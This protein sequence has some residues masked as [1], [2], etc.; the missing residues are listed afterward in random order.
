MQNGL[1]SFDEAVRL[2][3]SGRSFAVAADRALL[4]RL[5][6]GSWIGGSIPYFVGQDGGECSREKVFVSEIPVLGAAPEIRF[7]ERGE[8]PR[9]FA[10]APDNGFSLIVIPAFSQAHF[11]FARY[12]PEYEDAYFKPLVGWIAGVHLDD[13]DKER[14]IVAHGGQ[15]TSRALSETAAVVMH[16]PL[17]AGRSARI[18]IVNLFRPGRGPAIRFPHTGFG[19]GP[20]LIDGEPANLAEYLLANKIDT[21]VPLVADYCGAMVNVSIRGVDADKRSVD[22][23]APVFAHMEY[24]IAE[25]VDDYVAAFAAALP[26]GGSDA[27]FSCNCILNYVHSQLAGKRTGALV[28]P[29]TFGEVAYQLLNQTLVYLRIDG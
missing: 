21:R 16:V 5:P 22:F 6:P 26:C 27:V 23:Y 24:R 9:V 13:L 25:P 20:C 18:D 3:A 29:A 14:A 8:L 1:V 15:G 28:G 17:P 7:Y 11:D 12:A 4:A 2:L 19:A 10:D